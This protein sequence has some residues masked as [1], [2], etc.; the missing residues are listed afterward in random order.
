MR[1]LALLLLLLPAF[2]RAQPNDTIVEYTIATGQTQFIPPAL[3]FPPQL[4]SDN[5]GWNTG[6]MGAPQTL[7]Q[8]PPVS[9]GGPFIQR[10]PAVGTYGL[11][12]DLFPVST[13]V[14]IKN[15]RNDTL[16]DGCTGIVIG[17]YTV[18]T[19]SA[20]LNDGFFTNGPLWYDSAIVYPAYDLGLPHPLFDSATSGK[21]YIFKDWYDGESTGDFCGLIELTKPIG[22]ST[23]WV[24]MGYNTDT[25]FMN[26]TVFHSFTY[27]NVP[28]V[29]NPSVQ[30]NG[31]TLYYRYG[32]LAYT[33]PSFDYYSLGVPSTHGEGGGPLLWTDNQAWITYGTLVWASQSSHRKIDFRTYHLLLNIISN[34]IPNGVEEQEKDLSLQAFPNPVH[35]QLQLKLPLSGT[36]RYELDLYSITGQLM[37]THSGSTE[38]TVTLQRRSWPAGSY[39]AV[40]RTD[41]RVYHC[42][43]TAD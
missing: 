43:F 20:C 40:I 21:Y 17:P 19:M 1:S 37:E 28:D 29:I 24:G 15:M 39:I 30:Y 32:E 33:P 10:L 13:V 34:Y 5:T 27:P 25:A 38:G 42:R 3:P 2:L 7:S 41:E 35:E 12:L 8:T 22:L 36:Q 4:V 16:F 26:N 31:D 23:G 11:D 6:V 9:T 18:L 14:K